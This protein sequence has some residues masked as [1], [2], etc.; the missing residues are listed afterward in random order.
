VGAG[1]QAP[2]GS[3]VI[4]IEPPAIGDD[5]NSS[6]R[7]V[8]DYSVYVTVISLVSPNAFATG[9]DES[10][11]DE[12][13]PMSRDELKAKTLRGMSKRCLAPHSSSTLVGQCVC[14]HSLNEFPGMALALQQ[15]K[16]Q[17]E[18]TRRAG[19]EKLSKVMSRYALSSCLVQR[20]AAAARVM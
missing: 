10:D 20:I 7:C 18:R 19:D 1:P 16:A 9:D 3:T 13:R 8:L 17:G 4:N 2:A 14:S 11:D 15:P 6:F 12:E 5:N